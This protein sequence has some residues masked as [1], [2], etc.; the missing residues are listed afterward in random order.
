MPLELAVRKL[1]GAPASMYGF[2]DRGTLAAGKK[3]DV[4]VIDFDRLTIEAPVTR[5]DLPTGA[6]R[7]LQRSTGYLATI[8]NGTVVR[9][10]DTDTGARPGHLLR[11]GQAAS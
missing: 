2:A 3:A 4:N 8:A 5:A 9:R 6:S 11:S 7:I 1:T 10:D